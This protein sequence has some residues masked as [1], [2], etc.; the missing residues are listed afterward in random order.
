[1]KQHRYAKLVDNIF[2]SFHVSDNKHT[3]NT[4]LYVMSIAQSSEN[5]IWNDMDIQSW[6][7]ISSE[8]LVSVTTNTQK[9]LACMLN[10]NKYIFI[11]IYILLWQNTALEVH[12][13]KLE[14]RS[15]IFVR[16]NYKYQ[17][18]N[19]IVLLWRMFVDG[20]KNLKTVLC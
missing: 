13:C 12:I 1:M 10:N 3:S 11:Y 14:T 18:S 17:A 6:R 4:C 9:I 8:H 15:R 5:W 19:T 2:W 16:F 20:K 7:T